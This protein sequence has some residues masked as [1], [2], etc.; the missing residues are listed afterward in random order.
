MND[1]PTLYFRLAYVGLIVM[2]ALTRTW[3]AVAL[4]A[5]LACLEVALR[6]LRHLGRRLIS[7]GD[8]EQLREEL[9]DLSDR[10]LVKSDAMLERLNALEN[11]LGARR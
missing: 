8:G 3:S 10:V 2:A 9:T 5:V 7:K 4:L 1:L 11:R 6:V